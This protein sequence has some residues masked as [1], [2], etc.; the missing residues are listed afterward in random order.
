MF[1]EKY[2]CIIEFLFDYIYIWNHIGPWGGSSHWK[3]SATKDADSGY[4]SRYSKLGF[5]PQGPH[6]F[7]P[8][9]TTQEV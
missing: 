8:L 5:L 7:V 9:F 1:V 3:Y 4:I 6:Q 2:L